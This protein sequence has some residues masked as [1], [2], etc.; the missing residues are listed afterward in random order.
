MA[1]NATGILIGAAPALG[2]A[3][4]GDISTYWPGEELYTAMDRAA[5]DLCRHATMRVEAAS[6]GDTASGQAVYAMPPRTL[7]PIAVI[8]DG[9][10]LADRAPDQLEALSALWQSHVTDRPH[11]AVYG[12]DGVQAFRLTPTPASSGAPLT[13]LGVTRVPSIS[14][15]TPT[16]SVPYVMGE[17]F[18][19]S[20]VREARSREGPASMREV[21]TAADQIMALIERA[22]ADLWGGG[23]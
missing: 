10:H 23:Q 4:A 5:E 6:V 3:S 21:A 14:G 22:A 13:L 17:Y 2:L 7:Q 20:I 1:L 18:Y 12:L 11:A 15:A 19:L 9:E 8:C 16:I